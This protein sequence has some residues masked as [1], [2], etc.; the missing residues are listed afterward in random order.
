MLAA[1]RAKET[2]P[3]YVDMP[4]KYRLVAGEWKERSSYSCNRTLGR[5]HSV[6]PLSG[7]LFYLR[8]LLHSDHCRGA[9][10]HAN[11]LELPNGTRCET[12][13]EVCRAIGL[14][15]TDDEWRSAIE[16][17]NQTQ[18]CAKIRELFVT[19]LMYCQVSDPLSLFE[20]YWFFWVDDIKRKYESRG[21]AV[22]EDQLRTLL[23]LDLET[24]LQSYEKTLESFSLPVPTNAEKQRVDHLTILEHALIREELD[25]DV[26]EIQEE[27][28]SKVNMLTPDQKQIYDSVRQ[29]MQNEEQLLCF[30]DARGGC[31]KTFLLNAI[32]DSVRSSEP[33]GCIALAMAT[34][35]IAATM[36]NLGR[37]FHSRMKA[38]IDPTENSTLNF[39]VQS[40]LGKLITRA[41]ILVIDEATM[42]D[43]YNLE[44]MDRS[45]RDLM[46]SQNPD[47]ASIPFGGKSIV[48]AGDFRQCLPVI[49]FG[50]RAITVDRCIK[51]SA[52]WTCF[53]TYSLTTNMRVAR[54]GSRKLRLF[55]EWLLKLGNGDMSR[56]RIPLQH[57]FEIHEDRP[58]QQEMHRFID[59]HLPDLAEHMDDQDWLTKRLILAPSNEEVDLFNNLI[60]QKL[61]GSE[62]VLNSADTLESEDLLRFNTEY[63]NA[64]NPKG[65][66]PHRLV[67]KKGMPVTLLRNL[68]PKNGLCNGTRLIFWEQLGLGLLKCKRINSN[69]FVFIPRV[70]FIPKEGS[71]SFLWRRRQFPIKPAFA[72]TIN[73]SQGQTLGT[74]GVWLNNPVFTHGQLYV[75]CSRVKT[76]DDLTIAAKRSGLRVFKTD[77]VVYREIFG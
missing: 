19:M 37:T 61:A 9:T 71:Y 73:K 56:V 53:S 43:R 5:V 15:S 75:A 34:T 36:L 24:R 48:L 2:L 6:H 77:N 72:S 47:A 27:L 59:H 39:T 65:F 14:L 10:S 57:K 42:L 18:Y 45:L 63:L 35:G 38:P 55:D 20:D 41:K 4:E 3:M 16:E 22:D 21:L 69:E 64:Q 62:H 49:D 30:I 67:L 8:L 12:Y 40:D 66:A 76:P 60:T 51:R 52:L 11:L 29:S 74:V 26:S 68:N 50:T 32:L 7:D 44:A 1:G 54:E 46:S 31:G 28:E 13:Q 23:L 25:F 58:V 70:I 33:N 17:A